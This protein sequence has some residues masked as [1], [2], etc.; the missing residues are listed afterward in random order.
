MDTSVPDPVSRLLAEKRKFSVLLVS[1]LIITAVMTFISLAGFLLPASIYPSQALQESFKSNDL[2]NLIVGVP[3]LLGSLWLVRRGQL[4]GL[5]FWSGALMYVVYNY[6]SYMVAMPLNWSY[7]LYFILVLGSLFTFLY[8]IH[9]VDR[10]LIQQRLS[11]HV[12]EKL[13][14]GVLV[15]LGVAFFFRALNI[16]A[17]SIMSGTAVPTTDL[18]VLISDIVLSLAWIISGV[19]LWERKAVG[20]VSGGALLFQGATLFV[21]LI[22]FLLLNPLLMR[23][24]F[25]L[26]AV[27][28]I[29]FMS[30]ICNI[31]FGLFVRGVLKTR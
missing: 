7:L 21:G 12:Y 27:I 14:G 2:V 5:L 20:Y 22:L 24:P 29:L 6:I 13:S 4:L 26:A 30:V 9:S 18:S 10:E 25:D 15:G 28:I 8:F 31:P 17:G 1:S 11:G 16:I 19:L 3:I 23:I